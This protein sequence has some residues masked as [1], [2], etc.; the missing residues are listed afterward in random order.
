MPNR[1]L[2]TLAGLAVTGVLALGGCA[3]APSGTAGSPVI[4]SPAAAAPAN[5][6]QAPCT[7]RLRPGGGG[8][9]A[10]ALTPEAQAEIERLRAL[11]PEQQAA[12]GQASATRDPQLTARLAEVRSRVE[13]ATRPCGDR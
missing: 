1:R 4:A 11:T 2:V 12:E 8:P 10:M 5:Q 9:S 6:G 3:D 13:R 7:Q